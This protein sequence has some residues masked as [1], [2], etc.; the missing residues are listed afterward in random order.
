MFNSLRSEQDAWANCIKIVLGLLGKKK[1]K[2][3]IFQILYAIFI[4]QSKHRG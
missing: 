2:G 3:K 1:K 4:Y